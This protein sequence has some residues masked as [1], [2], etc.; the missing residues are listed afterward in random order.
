VTAAD[1][2]GDGRLDLVVGNGSSNDFTVL[3]DQ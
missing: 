2:S 1:A 3:L